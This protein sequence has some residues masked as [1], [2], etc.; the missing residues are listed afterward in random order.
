MN[1]ETLFEVLKQHQSKSLLFEYKPGELVGANYHITEVKHIKVDSVDCGAQTDQWN[2]TIIQLWESP[3]EI[4]KTQ[5]MSAY[6]ALSILNKVGKMR[7][8][9]L[10]A[11]V[12]FEYSNKDFHTAQLFV[13]DFELTENQLTF[14]LAIEKTDCKAKGICGV[15]E[16]VVETAE[17]VM[18]AASSCCDPKSGCC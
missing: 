13:D 16:V 7:P 2:E 10:N 9:D 17:K 12:K 5:F 1:T 3:T 18:Q 6:K 15:P 11:E 4:G 8:Y 14:K